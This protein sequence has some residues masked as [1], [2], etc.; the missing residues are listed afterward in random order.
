MERPQSLRPTNTARARTLW[1][2]REEKIIGRA[3]FAIKVATCE[4]QSEGSRQ[5]HNAHPI[6]PWR[7]DVRGNAP[8][9]QGTDSMESL[10]EGLK[11][12]RKGPY[13]KNIGRADE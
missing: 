6:K 2:G 11:R 1:R 12:E 10:P 8:M 4:N 9:V 5:K 13:D 7:A 3:I